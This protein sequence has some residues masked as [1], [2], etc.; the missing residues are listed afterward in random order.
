MTNVTYTFSDD[1]KIA[2]GKLVD[3]SVFMIDSDM[4]DHVKDKKFWLCNAKRTCSY[5]ATQDG[6]PL[7]MHLFPH[8]K[9]F[10]IDHI[11]RNTMDNRRCNI[12][13]CTHQQNQMNQGLQRN[14]TSGV[15]GVCWH[16][17]RNKYT[18]CIKVCQQKIH[19]GYYETFLEATQARNV[20]MECMFG[21]FG[22]YNNVPPA[23]KWIREKV[24]KQCKRFADLS[25]CE[26]FFNGEI[27]A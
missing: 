16:K 27:S 22:V 20:G 4:L 3:G 21:E 5:A 10:E 23:P 18:A 7:H 26:A 24:I 15:S 9:G 14:N 6:T 25:V 12:R 2:Y 19:L 1:G 13:Y 8:I 17:N 11:N